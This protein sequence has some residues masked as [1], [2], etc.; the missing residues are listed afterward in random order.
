L[1]INKN[2]VVLVLCHS[3]I[4]CFFY[5]ALLQP[6]YDDDDDD[7]DNDDSEFCSL[8][9]LLLRCLLF[10]NFTVCICS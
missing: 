10:Q 9:Y 7:V 1:V 4:E 3:K 2:Y 5:N 6:R 8:S